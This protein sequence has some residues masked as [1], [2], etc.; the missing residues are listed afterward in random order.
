LVHVTSAHFSGHFP[1]TH[2][3]VSVHLM[4]P[5]LSSQQTPLTHLVPPGQT[6]SF[7]AQATTHFPS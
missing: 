2:F 7:P 1:S 6:N 5:Q 3:W 4:L